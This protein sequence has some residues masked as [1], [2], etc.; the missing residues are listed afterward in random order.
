MRTGS[1]TQN[2]IYSPTGKRMEDTEVKIATKSL[3]R[4]SVGPNLQKIL[5]IKER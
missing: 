5:G 3:G 2:A 1:L 4:V